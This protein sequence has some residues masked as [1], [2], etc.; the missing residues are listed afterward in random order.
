VPEYITDANHEESDSDGESL[1]EE[2]HVP[3]EVLALAMGVEAK[4]ALEQ[5]RDTYWRFIAT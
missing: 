3:K 1:H 2:L 5:Q 4:E